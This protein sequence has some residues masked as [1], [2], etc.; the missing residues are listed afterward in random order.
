MEEEQI[1]ESFSVSGSRENYYDIVT[2]QRIW[3]VQEKI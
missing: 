3:Y 2:G 1:F